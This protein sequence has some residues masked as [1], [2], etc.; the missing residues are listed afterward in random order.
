MLIKVKISQIEL[1]NEMDGFANTPAVP[2][3]FGPS[4]WASCFEVV[5]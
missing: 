4:Q 5:I 2:S 3:L 1:K